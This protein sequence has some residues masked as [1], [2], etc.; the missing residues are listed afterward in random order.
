MEKF[1]ERYCLDNPGVFPNPDTAF[2]LG[3]SVI[4]LN[5]GALGVREPFHLCS[6]QAPAAGA[7]RRR[8]SQLGL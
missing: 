7:P 2:I 8:R 1:A 5:T 3:F 4:M 6:V